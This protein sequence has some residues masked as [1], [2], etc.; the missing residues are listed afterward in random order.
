MYNDIHNL[1]LLVKAINDNDLQNNM[2]LIGSWCEYF[3]Q[4]LFESYITNMMTRDHDILIR[5]PVHKG[6]GFHKTMTEMGFIYFD[7]DGKSKY[8][9]EDNEVE[10]LTT[11]TRNYDHLYKFPNI[12]LT[13]ECL[14]YMDLIENNLIEVYLDDM[15]VLI[16]SPPAYVLHKLI[17]NQTRKE[18]KKNKDIGSVSRLIVNMIDEQL[19]V[20]EL[21][22]MYNSLPKKQKQNVDYSVNEYDITPLKQLFKI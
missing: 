6:D 16:P 21:V 2:V 14:P 19:Y 5:R 10:F 4:D 7:N 1:K 17:I 9:K 11:L 22:I 13:A 20:N 8:M 3:Y 15:K 18:E 12:K